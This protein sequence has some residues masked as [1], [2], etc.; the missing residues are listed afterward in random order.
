MQN[1]KE[2][3]KLYWKHDYPTDPVLL[4]Y[5]VDLDED[6]YATRMIEIFADGRIDNREDK[7][8]EFVTE[9]A[10]PTVAEFNTAE[11]GEEF[12]AELT[13]KEEFENIWNTGI[14]TGRL[15]LE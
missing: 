4:I 15:Y 10:V 5:E 11:Y 7:G 2:Y 9:A 13:T 3:L 14:Y 12:A 1:D 6:R 8:F